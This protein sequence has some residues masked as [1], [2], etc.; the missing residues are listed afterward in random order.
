MIR[1]RPVAEQSLHLR[2]AK[3]SWLRFSFY[4]GCLRLLL[5]RRTPHVYLGKIQWS[6]GPAIGCLKVALP[7]WPKNTDELEICWV[8]ICLKC[9]IEALRVHC[10][11]YIQ[12]R[13]FDKNN[14]TMRL[15]RE[16]TERSSTDYWSSLAITSSLTADV[17]P[18][19]QALGCLSTS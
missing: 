5:W 9:A 14:L 19:Q 11:K 15:A 1:V 13:Q 12:T 3:G 8:G 17:K 6:G 18:V 7:S 16:P 4:R 2:L 10:D